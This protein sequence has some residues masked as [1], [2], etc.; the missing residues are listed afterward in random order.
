MSPPTLTRAWGL[1]RTRTTSLAVLAALS[2][3]GCATTSSAG[4]PATAGSSST[5]VHGTA[6]SC[7][8][9][10]AAQQFTA[11]KV[12]LDGTALSGATV[13]GANGILASPAR[14]RVQR[15]LKGAGAAV[16]TVQTAIT[17]VS[18][19][20]MV[21]EDGIRPRAG[22]RWRIDSST[23]SE[24]YATSICLGSHRMRPR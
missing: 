13:P 12:V 14:F 10:T 4:A 24:P 3:V 18:N 23:T 7:A 17:L 2:L 8:G 19:G 16:V 21:S 1:S 11:A 6:A 20:T 5:V 9:L 15:Y 22:E